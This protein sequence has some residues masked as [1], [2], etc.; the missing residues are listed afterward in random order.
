M[1]A[2]L[3]LD[4]FKFAKDPDEKEKIKANFEAARPAFEILANILAARK[5]GMPL[6][7]E[8]DYKTA[9]WDN[10]QAHRN[11]RNEELNWL[12]KLINPRDRE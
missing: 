2:R 10:L 6:P 11:G 3:A 5:A 8:E 12:V 9:S 4:W 1:A 7:S